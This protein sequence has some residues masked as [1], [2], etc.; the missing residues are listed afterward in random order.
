MLLATHSAELSYLVLRIMQRCRYDYSLSWMSEPIQK[1]SH[2]PKV[3]QQSEAGGRAET[4]DCLIM[5]QRPLTTLLYSTV[6]VN[7]YAILPQF[8][9]LRRYFYI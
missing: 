3:T 8:C 4:Q 1:L 2:L 7:H 6:L 5:E 9:F